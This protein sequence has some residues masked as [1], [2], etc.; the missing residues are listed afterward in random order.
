MGTHVIVQQEVITV[1]VPIQTE[2]PRP[3]LMLMLDDCSE[4][5]RD[6]DLVMIS[7]KQSVPQPLM[8]K[9]HVDREVVVKVEDLE[10]LLERH[11]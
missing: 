5:S 9:T 7:P 6:N 1:V 10:R 11:L 3:C 8:E 4:G 2:S